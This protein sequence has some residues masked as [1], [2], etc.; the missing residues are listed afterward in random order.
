MSYD[1]VSEAVNDLQKQGYTFD[2]LVDETKE[3]LICKAHPEL[4]PDE[5]QIDAIYRF[6]GN[7]NPDD[8]AV[9]YA[10]SSEKYKIKGVVVNSY[11]VYSDP[12]KFAIMEKLRLRDSPPA[13]PKPI[14][15]HKAIV[16]FSH[17]HHDGLLLCWK[18]RQGFRKGISVQRIAAY[19]LY[20]FEGAIRPHFEE[21]ERLLLPLFDVNDPMRLRTYEDHSEIYAQIAFLRHGKASENVLKNLADELEKHIRFEER[22]LF[23][24]VQKRLTEQELQRLEAL[25]Q[26]E[27]K[28][29]DT[30][31][32]DKFWE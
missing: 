1:T 9:V 23:N 6:E 16:G 2:F 13:A 32:D 15:R 3:C 22:E 24:E 20:F 31:W 25:H 17:E 21:E 29:L 14:K 27:K 7:S 18:I 28:D 10:V 4:S 5:F 19:T 11:G 8:E 30:G 26:H 12:V